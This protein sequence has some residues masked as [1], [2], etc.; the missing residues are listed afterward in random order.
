VVIVGAERGLGP[1]GDDAS[2]ASFH[3]P[4]CDLTADE[5]RAHQVPLDHR[6]KVSLVD[7]DGVVRLGFPTV[8][9]DIAA[10]V[11]DEELERAEPGADLTDDPLDLARVGQVTDNTVSGNT[12]LLADLC[13]RVGDGRSFTVFR[14]LIFNQTVDADRVTEPGE[15]LRESASD[16]STRPGDEGRLAFH[17]LSGAGRS[18]H[19]RLGHSSIR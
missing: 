6:A 9:R 5:N 8:Y 18:S 16:S 17:G 11:V 19:G 3:H 7:H 2:T 15:T 12:E 10:R 13:G 1:D 14:G 4:T